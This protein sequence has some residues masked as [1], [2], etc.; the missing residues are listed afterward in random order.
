MFFAPKNKN[1]LQT[2]LTG[3]KFANPVGLRS[4]L[5]LGRKCVRRRFKAGFIILDPP[6]DQILE[7]ISN[8]QDYRKTTVLAINLKTDIVR[9]FSLVYDFADLIII[10][11]DS[12]DGIS[13]PDI[14]DTAQLL[15]EIVSL[16]LCYEHYTPIY[17]RLT[18]ED[19]PDEVHPLVACAR[20]SGLD[21]IVAP[22]PR[23]VRLSKEECQGRMPIIGVAA[24]SEEALEEWR[25]G[26]DLV[27]TQ[28]R[29]I[30]L[31]RLLKELEKQTQNL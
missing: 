31:A 8:L 20:L 22:D 23:K 1:L 11:P 15:D 24:T 16:R 18:K 5:N 30:S 19:T 17:L 21:G 9:S 3:I 7:W 29:P 10:D 26:A 27:E 12:D 2:E 4:N 14:S 6:K 25:D 13:S 28:L